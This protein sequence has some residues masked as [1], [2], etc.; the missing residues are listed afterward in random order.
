MAKKIKR[1]K[2]KHRRIEKKKINKYNL[3]LA[4]FALMLVIFILFY[5]FSLPKE[6]QLPYGQGQ[7]TQTTQTTPTTIKPETY[8]GP[9]TKNSEC[10]ITRCIDQSESCVNTNQLS[11]YSKN[12]RTYSDW[13][14]GKQDF[15]RCSCIQN[16]CTMIR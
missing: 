16:A 6:Q 7:E 5:Y 2:I 8:G 3:Y 4:A 1:R 15:S 9:C 10:F 14:I 13:V 11:V 12:C